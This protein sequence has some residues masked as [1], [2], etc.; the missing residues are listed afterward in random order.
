MRIGVDGSILELPCPTGVERALVE[1][2]GALPG[3]LAEGD[4]IV[5]AAPG[6]VPVPDGPVRAV[7]TGGPTALAVW[8]ETHLAP[9]LQRVGAD[10]LWSPVAA[11][12]LRTNV[13]RVATIHETPWLVRRHLEGRMRERVHQVRLRLAARYARRLICPSTSS[14]EQV[15][16]LHPRAADRIEVV[17]HGVPQAF[18]RPRDP[19]ATEAALLGV[20]LTP[21]GYH[22]HVG[23]SRA[24]K[25]VPLLLRAHLD[26][27]I[28]GGSAQL[29]LVGPGEPPSRPAPGVV[30]LGY[31]DDELLLHLYDGARALVVSSE[32][33]GFGIPV[34]EAMSRGLPV[35]AP[36]VG[37]LPEA[38]GG[39][40]LLVEPLD[41][42]ALAD[43]MLRLGNDPDLSRTLAAHGRARASEA[44]WSSSATRLLEVLRAA[45]G[46]SRGG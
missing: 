4:E 23:G 6:E 40:A 44:R 28:A 8:R 29:V 26:H 15:R 25:N 19:D 12:P 37:G 14:A 10:V 20:G 36:A 18:L 38:A 31:V 30:H 39:A 45:A 5:V 13:P 11:I 24:R 22:L 42:R 35:I 2:L 34:L 33:E 9:L 46:D 32:S 3:V 41:Q 17:P 21:G 7:A 1:L 16:A 27:R 43:A